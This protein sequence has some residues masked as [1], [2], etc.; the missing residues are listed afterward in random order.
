MRRQ[1]RL[2]AVCSVVAAAVVVAG[3]GSGQDAVAQ[4]GTFDFVSPG[5]KTEIF[6]DPP[7]TR[8]T[9]GDLSGPDLFDDKTIGVSA[10]AGKVVV[11]NIWGSWC[12]PCRTETP[13][14]EKVFAATER[15]GVA[16]LGIDVRDRRTAAQDFVTDR[17]VRYPSI[18]DPEMRSL[19]ALG[20]GY[21]TSVVPTTLV[22]DREHRVAAVF[23]KALLVEDLQPVVERVA[24]ER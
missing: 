19:I 10:F 3:C 12:A 15:L 13:E 17:G 14:L 11:I 22:L 21:P 6:Y 8:G 2:L 24:A 18:F 20:K 16:F 5:G 7:D 23:L 9:I 4:G 1:R